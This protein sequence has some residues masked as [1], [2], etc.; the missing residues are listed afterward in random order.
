ML[1]MA[2]GKEN[3]HVEV[4]SRSP[5][6]ENLDAGVEIDSSWETIKENIKNSAKENL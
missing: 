3:Y 1:N 2:D 6:L 4:S 5:V